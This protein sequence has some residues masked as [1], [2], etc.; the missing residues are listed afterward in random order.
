MNI[1]KPLVIEFTGIP[2]SGK[3]TLITSLPNILTRYG[4]NVETMQEDAEIVPKIIPK[5][6]W[7]RNVWIT[8]GQLQ[9][10]LETTFSEADIILLDRG[11]YDALFWANSLLMEGVCTNQ[12]SE[13]LKSLIH[14]MDVTFNLKPDVVFIVDVSVEESMRRRSTISKSTPSISTNSFLNMYKKQLSSFIRTVD[15]PVYTFDTTNLSIT[16]MQD[17]V[18]NQILLLLNK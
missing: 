10:L 16:E 12:E 3:T 4:F 9:S 13:T 7:I 8:F 6:T 2:D 14:E 11:F 17:V 1:R 5:K 15:V 18:L